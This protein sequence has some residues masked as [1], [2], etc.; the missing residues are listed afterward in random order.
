MNDDFER[1]VEATESRF[2]GKYRATVEAN[3][4]KERLGR[5]EVTVPAVLGSERLWAMPCVPLAGPKGVGFFAMPPVG[6][7]C[8]VEFEG[9][10]L[11][12]PIWSGCFWEKEE[13]PDADAK[14]SVAFLRTGPFSIRVD[15][16]AGSV[17]IAIADGASL[18]LTKEDLVLTAPKIKN[19]ANGGVTELTSGGLDAMNGALKV[20]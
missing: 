12:H 11:D 14:P 5:I 10:D 3:D 18:K 20:V 6:A 1:F 13:I 16:D 9:G 4:D 2:Y 7:R 15:A 8:W 19:D 17:V